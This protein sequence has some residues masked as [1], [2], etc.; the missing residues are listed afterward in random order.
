MKHTRFWTA[1]IIL[2]LALIIGFALSVPHTRDVEQ[3]L[4]PT[5]ET[6]VPLVT[7][8]DAFKKGVHTI[9]GS[10]EASN[11]CAVLAAEA[12]LMGEATSTESILIRL[13]LSEDVGVCL[14]VPTP[15]DFSVT[16]SAPA[17]LPLSATINDSVASTTIS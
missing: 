16:I 11:A 6:S 9:T 12:V 2:A 7:L 17:G 8:H 15:M 10:L 5:E 14:Q 1:A 3:V 4:P 13:S